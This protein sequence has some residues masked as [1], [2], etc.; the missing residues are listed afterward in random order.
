MILGN[1]LLGWSTRL[2]RFGFGVIH[3]NDQDQI[4]PKI[5]RKVYAQTQLIIYN[6]LLAR[7]RANSYKIN[8]HSL[9]I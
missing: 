7:I 1:S 3:V 8:K 5:K 6:K 9:K 4:Q 2:L